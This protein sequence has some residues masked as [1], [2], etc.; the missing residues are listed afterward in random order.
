MDIIST[1]PDAILCHILSF[2]ETKQAV[3]TSILSERWKHLWLSVP[4]LD[5][6]NTR[7]TDQEA[8]FRFNDFVYSVL[9]S[10]DSALPIK[11]FRLYVANTN[12]LHNNLNMPSFAKWINFVLQRGGVEYLDLYVDMSTWPILPITIFSCTTLV[13]LKI[14]F[15]WVVDHRF[16]TVLLLPSLKTLHLQLIKFPKH[17]D[18]MLLL[19]K[20]PNLEDLQ[21]SCLCF[22]SEDSLSCNEWKNFSLSNL[23][24]AVVDSSYFK[25]PMKVLHNVRSLSMCIAQAHCFNDAIPTFHNLTCMHLDSLNSRCHFLVEVFK[26]CPK[27]QELYVDEDDMNSDDQTWT[28]NWVDPDFVPQ[29]LSLHFRVCY[30]SSFLGLQ[31]ELQLARY[32]LKNARVL[33]TMRICTIGE[34]EIK[35][36][37]SSFP[38][39]SSSCKLTFVHLPRD[40]SSVSDSSLDAHES[41]IGSNA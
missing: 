11:I 5:F 24:K 6:S 2:L 35:E 12:P 4:V 26:H 41:S 29:C 19:A 20:F 16:S 3:A 8:N 15:F 30:L 33:Q 25:F 10:R 31:S 38:R 32:I 37:L 18:F 14:H 28:G 17:Q 40:F 36:L 22:D 13:V 21:I 1:L 34:P 23:T 39:A 7:L 27:L 9:L